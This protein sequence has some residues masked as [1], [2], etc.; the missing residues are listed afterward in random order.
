MSD[1]TDQALPQVPEKAKSQVS[2]AAD[3]GKFIIK[4]LVFVFVLR[5]FIFQPVS[6]P[7]ES[8]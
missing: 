4:L 2:E 8:M 5:S 6:I 1:Q 7:S 3:F